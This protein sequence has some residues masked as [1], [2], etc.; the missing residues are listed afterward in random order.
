MRR[1]SPDQAFQNRYRAITM[2]AA[3]Y[4]WK[5]VAASGWAL[6]LGYLV[7][8]VSY[9]IHSQLTEGGTAGKGGGEDIVTWHQYQN[10]DL[11]KARCRK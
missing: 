3:R 9:R 5:N 10:E 8:C 4:A 6:G 1:Q 7:G 2:G 11:R